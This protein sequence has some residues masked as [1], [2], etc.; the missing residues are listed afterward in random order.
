MEEEFRGAVTRDVGTE[1]HKGPTE[2]VLQTQKTPS[3]SPA[4]IKE[5]I[6]VL[7][8][9]INEHDQQAKMKATPRK[10]AYVD[11]DKEAPTGSLAR[12]P[13]HLRRSR[14]LEDRSITKEKAR[15]ERS[16]PKGKR[17]GRQETSSDSEREEGSKDTCED[18]NSPYKR[19]KP[20]P[21]PRVS[22]A[23]QEEWPMP[24][25]C[26]MF[27]QTLGGA[28]RNWFDDLDP[29]SVNSFEELSSKFLEEFSQQKRYAKDPT[30]IHGIK[31]RQNEGLQT[32]MDRFKS[33]SSH[34][35]GVPPVLHIS[36]FMHGHGHPE[37]GKKLND[38]IPKTV[39]E[40]FER[41]RAFIRGEVA[42]G[43][44]KMVHP[45]Q[46]DNRYIRPTW[47]EG[48]EK[49]RN[50]G[51]SREARRN[52]GVYTPYPRKD[53]FTLL[54]KTPKEILAMENMSFPE[55]PPL[56]GTLE[57]QNLNKFCDY[58]RDRGHNTNDCY[59]L[60]KQ[61]EEAVASRK[62]AHLVKD[63]LRTNQRNESQGRNSAKVINMIREGGNH[64]RSFEEGRFGLTDELT[65]PAIPQNQLTD[66]PI[67]LEGIIEGE[68]HNPLG[69]IDLRVT[70]GRAG[71]SKTLLM[72]FAIINC[73]SPYNVIIGRTRMR[74]L[75]AVGSTIH[76]MIKFPTNQGIVTMETSRE[77]LWECRQL[78]RMQDSRKEVQWRQRKEQMSRIREQ[79]ILIT[80]SSSGR[81]P[82]SG[83]VSLEKHGTRKTQR[84]Y[85]SS[86][87][88]EYKQKR[89]T[90]DDEEKTGFH[91]EEGV[92]CFTHMPKELKNSAATLQRMM[93]EIDPVT[94][95]FGVKG[96]RFL[97][98]MVTREGVRADP[99]KV[100][101]IILNPTLKSPNQIRSLFLQLAFI[102]KFIPKMAELQY[103]IRKVRMRFETT[104]R[105]GWTNEAEKALQRIKRKLNKLQTLAVPKE[106][107]ILMLCLRQK[108]ETISS[109]LLV[110]REGIQ[111]H[112]SYVKVITDGPMEEILKLSRK[113]GRLAKWVAE[114]RTYDI[115]Y[116]L[117]K[118]AE[119]S[120]VKKFFG[121]EEQVEETPDANKGGTLNLSRKLQAK[122][123]PTPRAW[124]LYLGRETIE[125]GSGVGMILV[126]PEEKM[127][128]YAIRLKFNAS[129]HA[130]DCEAL[131]TG[132]AVSISKGMKDLHVFMDSPK[133]VSDHTSSK[134]LN[135]K[136]K[137]L[138]GLATIKLEFLNQE[139]SVGIKTRPSAEETSSSKKG[140][141]T[142]NIPSAKPNYNW[143]ASGSN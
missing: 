66:E 30:E 108:D 122:S 70:M 116:I 37:L 138:T 53:T 120:V 6:D 98:F 104:E 29:K 113:E 87:M 23:E 134:N 39:D 126:N 72:E 25:W 110:E 28:A 91:T 85:A 121:Q 135:S 82:N 14:R 75:G 112:V 92:Y 10:L 83:P 26:K 65:F 86:A 140:K 101:T 12:E 18:L 103:P 128:S 115:S 117:R 79:V 105:S 107:E 7:R 61:I 62:L 19:P 36:A 78:E 131:L 95:S 60:K 27:R 74:S 21:L 64:K 97:G 88:N 136:A 106:G 5:N 125:K 4:F 13:T 47:T 32:F 1:T 89:I 69:V 9:M 38:K 96:G 84:K 41:V 141:A 17:S 71:R 46:G 56:I 45:S 49:A 51:G 11:S 15:K 48:L 143:E 137:V 139:V 42:A 94:S 44:A 93:E 77:S 8:T 3:P 57:K 142:S 33:E 68:T 55:P 129:N 133:L 100:Q 76:S 63:I 111:I 31:R 109:V 119:G 67:I 52:M 90:G 124:R 22:S 59:Q 73:H 132:L 20:T 130:M 102:S 50:R 80:K 16:K 2:P 99:Q 43:T 123:I 34:I 118:E 24:V 54:I 40:M 127:Y 81:G 58:H 114:I 35:K